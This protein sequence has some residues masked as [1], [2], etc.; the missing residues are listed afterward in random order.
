MTP[1]P[2][3]PFAATRTA[4]AKQLASIDGVLPGTISTRHMR[5]GKRNCACKNDPP[6]LHGPYIQWT[7][8]LNGKTVTRLLTPEQLDRYQPWL[9]N[10]RRA[11]DILHKLE[12]ASIAALE[13]LEGPHKPKQ[14]RR[15]TTPTD[16]TQA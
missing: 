3:L 11:K 12:T 13:E 7:R 9:D 16:T 10:A 6:Q 8:T 4:L 14:P 5:C 2:R 15:P 1:P